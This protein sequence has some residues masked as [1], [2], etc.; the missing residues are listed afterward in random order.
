MAAKGH[1]RTPIA[2]QPRVLEVEDDSATLDVDD[3]HTVGEQPQTPKFFN[4]NAVAMM[5]DVSPG[6]VRQMIA[7]GQLKAMWLGRGP[8]RQLCRVSST[9]LAEF[10]AGA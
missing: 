3:A 2:Q 10:A 6:L 1:R 5:L 7:S 9:Q 4:V 8:A